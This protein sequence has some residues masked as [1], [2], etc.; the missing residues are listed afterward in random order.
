M[1]NIAI[2][3][4]L[5][6]FHYIATKEYFKENITFLECNSFNEMPPL[7]LEQKADFL[8]MAI[9]NSIAGAILPNLSLISAYDLNIVG[10]IYLPIAHNLLALKGTQI[11]DLKEV[12]SHSMALLQC[13]DFF[14]NY[15]HIKLV[16]Y[17]DTALFAKK[18]ANEKLKNVGAIASIQAS[19]LY[20]LEVLAPNIQDNSQNYTRFLILNKQVSKTNLKA[21]KA[22]L[23]FV[24]KHSVGSLAKVLSLL[25]Q[26]NLN[27][28][29]IQ[30]L[31]IPSNP[32][33][34]AF[35][36]EVTFKD[37]ANYQNALKTLQQEVKKLQILGEYEE[38]KLI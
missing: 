36:S 14:K 2:Q 26:H 5:G 12:C 3:G 30:S 28:C 21:S 18:I 38:N 23:S 13:Q 27:L 19:S 24:L 10:E 11:Q 22:S 33:E 8:V 6:S 37:Y 17:A 7:L 4:I 16:E 32:F 34:Y 15:P 20:H 31:P 29:K 9:E 25:A 1:P 35:F